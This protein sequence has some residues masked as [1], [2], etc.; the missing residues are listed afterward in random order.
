M[1]GFLKSFLDGLS[2]N[3]RELV[4]KAAR[5]AS[6]WANDKIRMG[7]TQLIIEL[8]KR[9]MQVVIPDAERFRQKGKPAVEALFSTEWPVT[10][11]AEVLAQ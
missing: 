5:E 4:I 2:K 1:F 6:N 7:E 8:Q 3:D 11:W 9:G 10:T